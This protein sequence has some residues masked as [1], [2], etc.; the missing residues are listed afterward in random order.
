[1]NI[2]QLRTFV[3][4]V[5]HGSFSAA[6]RAM[7]LS[8]PAVTMQIQALETDLGVTLVNRKYRELELTEAGRAL[9]PFAERALSELDEARAKV[10]RLSAT[11]SGRLVMA[12]STTPGQY[13]LP[14]LLGAF[15]SKYPQVGVSLQ[16]ADTA[17][18][19][20][21]VESRRAHLGMTGAKLPAAKV[22]FEQMGADELIIICPS[23][24][25]LASGKV[26]LATVA[27]AP[28]IM[29]EEGSG[30]RLIAEEVFRKAGIDPGEMQVVTELGTNEA[31]I[32]AV[33]GGMGVAVVSR[34]AAEKALALG[35]IAEV[36]T[37]GFPVTRPFY[38]V[39][40]QQTCTRAAEAFLGYLRSLLQ[41]GS[42]GES[43]RSAT[44]AGPAGCD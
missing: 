37:S 32:N 38:A 6:A 3:A 30:T 1:M 35:T 20:E 41:S 31:I 33:E 5:E 27:E 25:P 16:V 40:P 44:L 8:Q 36:S 26:A 17:L 10:E 24:S 4:L 42:S 28:F 39:L 9:L 23:D 15:L 12:A 13:V 34:F 43:A 21:A 7:G 19:V 14:K 22:D 2:S 29:R 11:V 18:V